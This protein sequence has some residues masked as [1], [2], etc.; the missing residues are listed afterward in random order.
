[1]SKPRDF[2]YCT[3]GESAVIGSAP[4]HN[5]A[6]LPMWSFSG[7]GCVCGRVGGI[8]KGF[9]PPMCNTPATARNASSKPQFR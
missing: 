3:A 2:K 8:G 5:A 9:A 4:F 7:R 1:M 6:S